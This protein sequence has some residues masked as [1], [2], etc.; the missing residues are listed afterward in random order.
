[1]NV[2]RNGDNQAVE[3]QVID[4]TFVAS[5]EGKSLR[6][7]FVLRKAG[8]ILQY[9]L[10]HSFFDFDVCCAFYHFFE[11]RAVRCVARLTPSADKNFVIMRIGAAWFIHLRNLFY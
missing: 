11:L 2:Y 8:D 1:M 10:F 7:S 5:G 4:T 3:K 9:A 6:Q